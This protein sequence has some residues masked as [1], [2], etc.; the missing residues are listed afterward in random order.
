[1][2]DVEM[3]TGS[4]PAPG[5][6]REEN[7]KASQKCGAFCIYA[8]GFNHIFKSQILCFFVF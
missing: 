3:Q 6:L 8:L 1:M 7:P 4:S 5:L 2:G